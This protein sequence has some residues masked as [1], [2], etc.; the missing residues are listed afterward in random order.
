[1]PTTKTTKKPNLT[2]EEAI[3]MMRND[4]LFAGRKFKTYCDNHMAKEPPDF[5]KAKTNAQWAQ[6]CFDGV[7]RYDEAN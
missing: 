3:E 4:L 1:M 6:Y 7:K 2:R 5:E